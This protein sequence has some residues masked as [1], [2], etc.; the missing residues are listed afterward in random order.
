[1]L[2]IKKIYQI[3]NKRNINQIKLPFLENLDEYRN[4]EESL[5]S[6]YSTQKKF[7]LN[8]SKKSIL[9]FSTKNF[10]IKKQMV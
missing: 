2:N 8:H 1:M 5:F 10:F 7:N 4:K 6:Y 3:K 9:S